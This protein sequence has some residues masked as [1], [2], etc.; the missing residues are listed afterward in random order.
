MASS[1]E[2]AC[3]PGLCASHRVLAQGCM[4]VSNTDILNYCGVRFRSCY[5]SMEIKVQVFVISLT[6]PMCFPV[7]GMEVPGAISRRARNELY[8][9]S[10]SSTKISL[11]F[12]PFILW[13]Q[14]CI[15]KIKPD[16]YFSSYV[17]LRQKST[18]W[19]SLAMSQL[20]CFGRV[21]LNSEIEMQ[22]TKPSEDG[23]E[24]LQECQAHKTRGWDSA[25]VISGQML[26]VSPSR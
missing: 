17:R 5:F 8:K 22:Y 6:R 2:P 14:A 7:R 25:A 23:G 10:Y 4:F 16:L 24:P 9:Y 13:T 21:E 18:M 15:S 11:P 26:S 12:L 20:R 3:L 19:A 1:L